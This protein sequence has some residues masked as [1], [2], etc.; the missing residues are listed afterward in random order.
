[1]FKIVRKMMKKLILIGAVAALCGACGKQKAEPSVAFVPPV[2]SPVDTVVF[3]ED[4]DS[5]F[6]SPAEEDYF[7]GEDGIFEEFLYEFSSD[8][9]M[10]RHRTC[11]PLLCVQ[12]GKEVTLSEA[13]YR[14]IELFAQM[15]ICL[16]LF[17]HDTEMEA[18]RDTAMKK[19]NVECLDMENRHVRTFCFEKQEGCWRLLRISEQKLASYRHR[20]FFTFY[21]RFVTD[22]LYQSLHVNDPMTFVTIDPEDDFNILEANIDM[23]QWFAFRPMLPDGLLVNIDYGVKPSRRPV[24]KILTCRSLGGNFNHTSYFRKIEGEWILTRFEDMSN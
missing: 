18:E 1:M 11:F 14:S 4:S 5:L 6:F 9:A 7:S 22:S 21:H 19:A 20:E 8:T 12:E 17:E 13:D 16:T 3:V 15:D 10:Q 2:V 24:R 23:E